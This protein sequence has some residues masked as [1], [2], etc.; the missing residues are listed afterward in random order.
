VEGTYVDVETY[1]D[2]EYADIDDA[3]TCV[4]RWR[5]HPQRFAP[6]LRYAVRATRP[7]PFPRAQEN[8]ILWKHVLDDTIKRTASVLIN[9]G[10]LGWDEILEVCVL[11]F[12][13]FAAFFCPC[14]RPQPFP[15]A[16]AD[17]P[18]PLHAT[19]DGN[20]FWEM[21]FTN[22]PGWPAPDRWV[23]FVCLFL[24]LIA[25][26]HTMLSKTNKLYSTVRLQIVR[27]LCILGLTRTP[28]PNPL[29]LNPSHPRA[30]R[31]TPHVSPD[32]SYRF[33]RQN[34]PSPRPSLPRR[35]APAGWAAS[36]LRSI[37]QK[38]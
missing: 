33:S 6:L 24:L 36:C 17:A 20:L 28:N 5:R 19:Q 16:R 4:V 21:A 32:A 9:N 12:C 13:D 26:E 3:D 25:W 37:F 23:E 14:A 22:M 34:S 10:L 2:F 18:T 30:R 15:S 7:L 1:E 8:R 27:D 31:R 38:S 35:S 11:A 29:T